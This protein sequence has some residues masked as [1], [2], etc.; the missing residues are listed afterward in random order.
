MT[1]EEKARVNIDAAIGVAI[2]DVDSE[3]DINLQR[4][5]ALRQATFAKA[6]HH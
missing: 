6:F 1:T 4:V 3:A 2:R 5:Q